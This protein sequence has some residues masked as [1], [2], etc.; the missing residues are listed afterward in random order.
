MVL[1]RRVLLENVPW[2]ARS[3]FP[4]HRVATDPRLV[5]AVLEHWDGSL[6]LD[7]AA[8]GRVHIVTKKELTDSNTN[9]AQGGIAGVLDPTE[10]GSD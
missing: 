7:L 8:H 1:S 3:G 10:R 6:A 5:R 2:E 9:L 4:L